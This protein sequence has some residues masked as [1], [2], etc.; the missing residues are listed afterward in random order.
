MRLAVLS[1]VHSNFPALLAVAA[2][3]EKEAPDVVVVAGDLINRG[4]Q[5]RAVWEFVRE[6]NWPLIRGNHEDY[7]LAQCAPMT[8]GDELLHALWQPARWT[9]E[10]LDWD[11]EAIENLPPM[12][13]LQAPDYSPV[14]V[15]H[16]TARRNNEGIFPQT[17]DS[18][19]SE[20]IG[21]EP[22]PLF[23]CGHTHVPLIRTHGETLIVNAGAA[24][25]PF[26]GDPRGSYALLD[27]KNG[28]TA[29]IRRVEYDRACTLKAFL[30]DGFDADGGP[31][32]ALV[33][34][35]V[36][37]ARPHLGSFIHRYA[38]A[39]RTNDLTLDAAV[40]AYLYH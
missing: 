17:P 37:T 12:F 4:P 35:E 22:P 20:L 3:I 25:M 6:K 38:E 30:T 32:A 19:L 2:A 26:D 33:K 7:V 29:E 18:A 34:R 16:G 40:L 28:W 5:P 27:W 1:D 31:M 8:D 24:G 13:A 39:V 36:E 15:W 14:E 10:Q 21:E 9:A 11:G 23:A